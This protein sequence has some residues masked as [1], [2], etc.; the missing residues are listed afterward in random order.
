MDANAVQQWNGG[1]WIIETE[2]E[3]PDA[4]EGGVRGRWG[5]TFGAFTERLPDPSTI[6]FAALA[7]HAHCGS[8]SRRGN[9]WQPG[10]GR[11]TRAGLLFVCQCLGSET[12]V[13]NPTGG[14]SEF[15]RAA[16]RGAFH[17]D[18]SLPLALPS[19]EA[20]AVVRCWRFTARPRQRDT[21]ASAN[22]QKMAAGTPSSPVK[23]AQGRTA[24]T[25]FG[26]DWSHP[27]RRHR[28]VMPRATGTGNLSASH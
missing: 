28:E 22:G 9:N 25:C 12:R 11:C 24:R 13:E 6:R 17:D 26:P 2:K 8:R 19:P 14:A 27:M 21:A 3:K 18:R 23:S 7:N 16:I 1:C 15:R 20:P 4:T 5:R 10:V